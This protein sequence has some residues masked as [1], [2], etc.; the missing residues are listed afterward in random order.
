ML[1]CLLVVKTSRTRTCA[2]HLYLNSAT[3][4]IFMCIFPVHH[5][6]LSEC[7]FTYFSLLCGHRPFYCIREGSH[8][9]SKLKWAWSSAIQ[10]VL[11]A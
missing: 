11:V 10:N 6:Q 5:L 4:R 7:R 2:R 8:Y 9:G 1:W 3:K